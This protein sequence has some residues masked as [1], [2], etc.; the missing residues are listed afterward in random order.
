[1]EEAFD[2]LLKK[3]CEDNANVIKNKKDIFRKGT[4]CTNR[5]CGKEGCKRIFNSWK[6]MRQHN[7]Y[8]HER[9]LFQVS[10]CIKR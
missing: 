8:I 3:I 10:L 9:I 6:Q 7:K 4:S 2:L 1:M 5:R